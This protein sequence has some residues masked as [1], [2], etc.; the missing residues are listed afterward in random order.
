MRSRKPVFSWVLAGTLA[1][2]FLAALGVTKQ[3]WG[4]YVKPPNL[5]ARI[6]NIKRIVSFTPVSTREEPDGT[7]ALFA[8]PDYIIVKSGDTSPGGYYELEERVLHAL[9]SRKKLQAPLEHMPEEA[10]ATVYSFIEDTGLVHPGTPRYESAGML[11]A[12]VI[13]AESGDGGHLLLV[14]VAG[15]QVSNDHYPYYEF[16]FAMPDGPGKP[17]LLSCKRWFYDNAGVEG[18]LTVPVLFI[19]FSIPAFV[20]ALLITVVVRG[21]RS[22][23]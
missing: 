6:V 13:E 22:K 1:L 9:E 20:I 10:L 14:A 8:D 19:A 4:Y 7:L 16:L 21:A 15:G 17:H 2:A 3:Y 11:S 5:D 23:G 12:I 18:I